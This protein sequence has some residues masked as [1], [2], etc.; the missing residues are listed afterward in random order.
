M[1]AHAFRFL[2]LALVATLLG[3]AGGS[4]AVGA[5]SGVGR[6]GPTAPDCVRHV[7]AGEM[8][9]GLRHKDGR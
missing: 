4:L 1:V 3:V 7:T 5:P 9:A 8:A 6:I 2:V